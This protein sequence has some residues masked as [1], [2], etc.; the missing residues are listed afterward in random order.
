MENQKEQRKNLALLFDLEQMK[1]LLDKTL[2]KLKAKQK[3][4]GAF[5]WFDGGYDNRYITQHIVS[6]LGHLNKLIKNNTLTINYQSITDKAISF[7][8]QEFIKDH[9]IRMRNWENANKNNKKI[10]QKPEKWSWYNCYH[11]LHYFY[12]RSFYLDKNPL[13]ENQKKIFMEYFMQMQENWQTYSLYEKA[14]TALVLHR[15]K[16]NETPNDI[17]TAFKETSSN[18]EE[19]GMYWIAN[20][21]SWY[22]YQS[23]IETQALIIEAF[24]EIANDTQSTDLMKV[25]LIKNKQT[26]SWS[27]TKATTE[28]IY[29]LLLQ[30]SDF[31]NVENKT[32][33]T[34]GNTEKLFQKLEENPEEIGSGYIKIQNKAEEIQPEMA[35]LNIKNNN[36]VPGFGGIYW[37][38]F[39]DL[40]KIKSSEKGPLSFEKELY[41]KSPTASNK[42]A[43]LQQI[44]NKNQL[45]IGDRVTVRLIISSQEDIDYVHLKDMRASCFEP[46]NVLS[47]YQ[48]QNGMGYYMS[49]KDAA[50]HFFFDT[51]R[52]GTFVLE[53]EVIVNNKGDFSNGISTLQSMYAPEYSHHSSGVRVGVE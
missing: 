21:N 36:K 22:W 5:A 17:I 47:S 34:W 38:Y 45:K 42:T 20:K 4:N 43:E 50:T 53:Y 15:F 3:S 7:L 31:V 23:P 11:E 29:A 26:K 10:K 1:T 41:I 44:T 14:M 8:D 51:L 35:T 25:W 46:V 52:K 48:W 19:W 30:G 37:Q 2:E 39:E 24:T 6:G 12:A 28:A 16:V 33:I 27:N 32:E 49:T 18:N 40:D 13:T 9:E